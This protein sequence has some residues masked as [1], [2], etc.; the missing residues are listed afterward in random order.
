MIFQG[1]CAQ[2]VSATGGIILTSDS[3]L[4]IHDLGEDGCVVFFPDIDIDP[5]SGCLTALQFR[6]KTIQKRLSLKP[7]G[8]LSQL[9][10]E[11]VSDPHAS[12]EQ[13][14]A[15]VKRGRAVS[16]SPEE[17]AEFRSQYDDPEIARRG[18][19][20]GGQE[21]DPRVSEIALDC[22]PSPDD[23]D[24]D[25]HRQLAVFLPFLLDSPSRTSAWEA[26]QAC[27]NMAYSIFQLGNGGSPREVTE[28]RRLQPLSAGSRTDGFESLQD[29]QRSLSGLRAIIS[30]T[31][32]TLPRGMS[33]FM[34]IS[35]FW[36]IKTTVGKGRSD[37]LSL[38]IL[39]QSFL[40]TLQPET[41]DFVHVLAQTQATYYS[42]RVLDQ[43]IKFARRNG[44][45]IMDKLLKEITLLESQLAKL[46]PLKSF[47]S[48]GEFADLLQK[49][50]DSGSLEGIRALNA[51]GLGSM[52]VVSMLDA[53]QLPPPAFK[54][55][56]GNGGK[57][58]KGLYSEYT[59]A[60]PSRPRNPF[61][62]LAGREE[63]E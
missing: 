12:L 29:L 15:A 46:P 22:L 61:E 59:M 2:N 43:A 55:R 11:M 50:L 3:D 56:K 23:D 7:P 40:G 49:F 25:N 9:A 63:D 38:Q 39:R 37:P 52:E 45:G 36:D 1:Y 28:F 34:A 19:V 57:K 20:F 35:F 5:N 47:P 62:A 44:K 54:K 26:S 33:K 48:L 53:I 6:V 4:L 24:V 41:W 27:R 60:R 21:L 8:G 31:G 10:F 13:A 16:S 58:R 17:Y 30:L 42:F 32:D 18:R 51:D 14:V